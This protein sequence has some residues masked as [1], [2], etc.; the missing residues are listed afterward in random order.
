MRVWDYPWEASRPSQWPNYDESGLGRAVWPPAVPK[1]FYTPQQQHE[2]PQQ[3]SKT[4]QQCTQPQHLYELPLP[5]KLYEL[6][7]GTTEG[8]KRQCFRKWEIIKQWSENLK[9]REPLWHQVS[10]LFLVEKATGSKLSERLRGICWSLVSPRYLHQRAAV[11]GHT[12]Y[13]MTSLNLWVNSETEYSGGLRTAHTIVWHDIGPLNGIR[14]HSH[15]IKARICLLWCIFLDFWDG[16]VCLNPRHSLKS[17]PEPTKSI[18]GHHTQ[19]LCRRC[20]GFFLSVLWL[21]EHQW[22][23]KVSTEHKQKVLE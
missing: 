12:Y 5:I 13:C 16:L 1:W 6:K 4:H 15:H 19:S 14:C 7:K 22:R 21:S 18:L 23:E 8:L 17:Q 10:C 3:N 11:Q 2:Q 9:D 20:F